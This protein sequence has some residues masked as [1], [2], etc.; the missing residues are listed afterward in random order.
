MHEG[1]KDRAPV[2]EAVNQIGK[3]LI[4]AAFSVHSALGPGLLESVYE[5]CLAEELRARGLAVEREVAVPVRYREAQLEVG[6]RLDL[7]VERCVIVEI[8]AID[9]L[10]SIH[11]ARTLTYLKFASLRLAYL[12]NFN[13]LRLK[14]GLRRVVL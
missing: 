1:H 7:L 11:T 9:A 10:A 13:V 8:K 2:P 14:D 6:F 12:I 3:A 4:D 5:T